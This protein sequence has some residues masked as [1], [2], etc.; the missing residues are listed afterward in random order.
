MKTVI[1][2]PLLSG[3]GHA[4]ATQEKS[5]FLVVRLDEDWKNP[6]FVAM[7]LTEDPRTDRQVFRDVGDFVKAEARIVHTDLGIDSSIILRGDYPVSSREAGELAIKNGFPSANA[8]I[9]HLKLRGFNNV[10]EP[11]PRFDETTKDRAIG[12]LK[13]LAAKEWSE[14]DLGEVIPTMG[15]LTV[16]GVL[17]IDRLRAALGE[18]CQLARIKY[19]NLQPDVDKILSKHEDMV[20]PHLAEMKRHFANGG[21]IEYRALSVSG[22][23]G[24][25]RPAPNPQW[26]STGDTEYRKEVGHPITPSHEG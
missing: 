10:V 1:S 23:W 2:Y 8:L 12:I 21:N 20:N 15:D 25:W 5:G 4:V 9:E 22:F 24:D 16:A 6:K 26:H 3:T 19:G 18:T 11:E 7:F 14:V 17:E 13:E